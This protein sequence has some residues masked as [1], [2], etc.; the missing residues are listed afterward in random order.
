VP[1]TL[2]TPLPELRRPGRFLAGALFDLRC[3]GPIAWRLFRSN[4]RIRYR[5]SWLGYLWLLLPALGTAAICAFMQSRRI[6]AVAPTELP[7]PIFVLA[8]MILW[9]LFVEAVNAPLQQ[10]G[11]G[12]QM[13]TRSRVP[14]EALIVAGLF[15]IAL[16]F[17][18]RLVVLAAML[19]LF[20]V[21]PAPSALLL[22]A[23]ALALA[24]LGLAIGLLL[25]PAGM[26]YDDVARGV[27]LATTFGLF[28][29]PVLYPLP[30][31][32]IL[33]LNP[34]TP[35]LETS[36]SWLTHGGVGGGFLLVSLLGL[37]ALAFAWLVY[38]LARPHLVARLG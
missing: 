37:V 35:L 13:I 8:G 34:V 4:L 29:T 36:R 3:S 17:A 24:V 20:R 5:R 27:T 12:R 31:W 10:L 9:Q 1:E 28:L 26:L 16:N 25:T 33:R 38:R 18:I 19:A 22:P 23:G 2:Y 11:A 15:E 30:A 32:G 6:V 14:H 7:Y 21:A